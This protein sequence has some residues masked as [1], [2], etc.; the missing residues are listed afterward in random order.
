LE[1][2]YRSADSIPHISQIGILVL[3]PNCRGGDHTLIKIF[4]S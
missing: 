4:E 2:S 3:P 1:Q